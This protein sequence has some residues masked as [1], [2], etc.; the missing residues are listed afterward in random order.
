MEVKCRVKVEREELI[1]A[2]GSFWA[3]VWQS[4]GG[5]TATHM[6]GRVFHTI[7]Y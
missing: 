3:L 5:V 2:G 6:E 7:T 4:H 1:T